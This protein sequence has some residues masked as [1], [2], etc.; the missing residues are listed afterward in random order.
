MR[1]DGAG[2][3]ATAGSEVPPA[4]SLRIVSDDQGVDARGAADPRGKR[5]KRVLWWLGA[6][7]W[8]VT[9]ALCGLFAVVGIRGGDFPAQDYRDWLFGTHGFVIW[10]LNWYG[11]HAALGYSVLFP[12]VGWLLGAALAT[13]L[14]CIA[15]SVLFGRLIGPADNWPAVLSRLAFAV[16]VVGDLIVGRAPFACAV[17]SS[18]VAVLAV[19]S[20]RPVVATWA[21]VVTSLF[22]PLGAAFLL[23]IAVAWAS[24]IGWRRAAPFAGAF[25]GLAIA[26]IAGDGGRF[27]FPW[28]TFVGQLAIVVLGLLAT[29]RYEH[30]VRRMLVLY[31]V[32]C[33]VLF[34]VPNPVGGNM[35]RLAGLVVLP[36]ATFVLLRD[37]RV[38]RLLVLA[39]PLIVFQLLPVVAAITSGA[40]DPSTKAEYYQGMLQYL[41]A[42]QQPLGRVEIPFTRNHWEAKYVAEHVALARGWE[43]QIDLGH[44]AVLYEPLSADAYKAWLLDNAVRYVALP[45]APLDQGGRAEKA[46]LQNPPSWLHPVYTNSHWRIWQVEGATAIATGAATITA[47]TTSGFSLASTHT[48]VTLVRLRW[49]P[50][51]HVDAGSACVAPTATGWTTVVTFVAGKTEVNVRPR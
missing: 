36:A 17:T 14:A 25:V 15:S 37:G 27:P 29:P 11:G 20:R 8:L 35:A 44:N 43:R 1:G 40:T 13:A 5:G 22:S 26:A 19:R 47:V 49:S 16:F 10:D 45:D 34:F 9:A 41:E 12:P 4:D 42:N 31:G 39:P 51:W 33:V 24:T 18:L 3:T 23:L 46:V 7:A 6:R 32:A 48:G 28:G 21:A 30:T 2:S 38:R 50:Y